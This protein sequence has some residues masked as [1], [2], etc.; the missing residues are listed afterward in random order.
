[1]RS[2]GRGEQAA[3][4]QYG[5]QAR[6]EVAAVKAVPGLKACCSR[7]SL[8]CDDASKAPRKG[9]MQAMN[10]AH[11]SKV[12]ALTGLTGMAVIPYSFMAYAFLPAFS[13]L[14]C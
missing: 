3:W 9:S 12:L 11:N 5:Q 13:L 14:A 6:Q 2:Q 10:I 8:G 1:M 4:R 7:Y